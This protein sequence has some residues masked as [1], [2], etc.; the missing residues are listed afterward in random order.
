M[1]ETT[2]ELHTWEFYHTYP[3]LE[4]TEEKLGCLIQDA[5]QKLLLHNNIAV[6]TSTVIVFTLFVI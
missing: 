4:T 3:E 5:L 6:V 2:N 1:K